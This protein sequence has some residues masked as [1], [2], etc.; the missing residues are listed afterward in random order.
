MSTDSS[1][2][3]DSRKLSLPLQLFEVA[4]LLLLLDLAALLVN[5]RSWQA[6]GITILWPTNGLL[7]GICLCTAR[8]RWGALL[9]VGFLVDFAINLSLGIRLLPGSVYAACNMLEVALAAWLM[10][11]DVSPR[12]N[13]VERRQL[14]S[15][16]LYGVLLA[17]AAASVLVNIFHLHETLPMWLNSARQWFMPDALGN[18]VMT[19]LYLSFSTGERFADRRRGEVIGLF[20][21]VA[22]LSFIVFS[23]SSR[24]IL[25]LLL[26][27]LLLLGVRLGLAGSAI[28]LLIVSLIGGAFTMT[29]HGPTMLIADATP[30]QR[31][32]SLQIFIAVCMLMLYVVEVATYERD[33]LQVSLEDSES[34]FRLLAEASSDVIVLTDLKGRRQY[35]SPAVEPLLG[36]RPEELQ[37]RTFRQIVHPDDIASL[38]ELMLR[39][40]HGFAVE[41]LCYRVRKKEGGYLWMEASLRLHRDPHTNVAVGFVNV[42][43]DI[44]VRKAAEDQLAEAFRQVENLAMVDGLTNVSNRRHFDEVFAQEWRRALRT[45]SPLSLLMVDVDH[46][47]LYNDLYGH[48]MGDDCL[49][50]IA[51][52]A[53]KVLHRSSDVFA[54]YGG[55]EFAAVLPD[56]DSA[57]ATLLAEQ[58]RAAVEACGLPHSANPHGV[59]TVSVGSATLV[60]EQSGMMT[61]LVSAADG[62]MYEAKADGRNCVRP[63]LML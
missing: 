31:D 29:G 49:K 4:V 38:K 1:G 42:V 60:P 55:E 14:T 28:G 24:P 39:A 41:P 46:F 51:A 50:A 15:L 35:I 9:A 17:P 36:W 33:Q 58:I 61:A 37:G 48:V 32:L 62:A 20:A 11:R 53:Q 10:H 6:G 5:V 40:A 22:A 3:D 52:A 21:L 26:P 47:K 7:L 43:R 12:P 59:V 25:Y 45:S 13:L 18:A 56:T 34:R 2:V 8:E 54:R 30:A 16:L 23:Q 27:V 44:T 19:P 63:A 57:G